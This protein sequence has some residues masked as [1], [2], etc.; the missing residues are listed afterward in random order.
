MSRGPIGR[1][2]RL[3]A[4]DSK[5]PTCHAG[6]HM[7]CR[8]DDGHVR[9]TPCLQRLRLNTTETDGNLET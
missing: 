1:A 2:Y 9:R 3:A 7:W 4:M 8:R 6:P 5:C